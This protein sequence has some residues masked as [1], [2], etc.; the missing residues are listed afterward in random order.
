MIV[1]VGGGQ[2]NS[3]LCDCGGPRQLSFCDSGKPKLSTTLGDVGPG[4]LPKVMVGALE[5]TLLDCES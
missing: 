1:G 5:I 2:R 3:P 4:S